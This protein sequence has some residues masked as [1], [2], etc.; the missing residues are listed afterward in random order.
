MLF[1]STFHHP[2]IATILLS[3]PF[4]LLFSIYLMKYNN[5]SPNEICNF[6][7]L[8][9]LIST[10]LQVLII[11]TLFLKQTNLIKKNKN[12]QQSL[13]YFWEEKKSVSLVLSTESG[14]VGRPVFSLCSHSFQKTITSRLVASKWQK[15]SPNHLMT[16]V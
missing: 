10:I 8:V 5:K 7:L 11:L 14:S 13:F 2:I 15:W 3:Y 1:R 16:W 4:F 12:F 9:L 6:L